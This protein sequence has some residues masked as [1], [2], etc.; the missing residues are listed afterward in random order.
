MKVSRQNFSVFFIMLSLFI[1]LGGTSLLFSQEQQKKADEI[2]KVLLYEQTG[3]IEGVVTDDEGNPLPGI[4]V[5]VSSPAMMGDK[6]FITTP[7]G[8]FRFRALPIGHY[9]LKAEIEDG[10]KVIISRVK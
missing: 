3:V 8:S 2:E 4:S 5:T 10:V 7:I 9:T 6:T 1:F